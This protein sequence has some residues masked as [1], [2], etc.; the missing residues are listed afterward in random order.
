MPSA[1]DRARLVHLRLTARVL[2][3]GCLAVVSGARRAA[4]APEA[5][6]QAWFREASHAYAAVES[7]VNNLEQRGLDRAREKGKQRFEQAMA[8]ATLATNVHRIA[9]LIRADDR[10]RS[11]HSE[12]DRQGLPS[13][14]V[15]EWDEPAG[16]Q[17]VPRDGRQGA[18]SE[19]LIVD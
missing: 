13:G 11:K 16:G 5:G 19:P 8:P 3:G 6:R 1:A 14:V 17:T 9:V 18:N 15:C 2:P 10:E 7:A 4:A 12:E